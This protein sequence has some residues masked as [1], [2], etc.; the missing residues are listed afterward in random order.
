MT[1]FNVGVDIDDVL[2]P[3]FRTAHEICMAAG[4]TNGV[5]PKTY[6]PHVEYGVPRG[7]W[8]ATLDKAA[9]EGGLYDVPPIPGAVEAL[10]RIYW[11]GHRISLVTARGT[12]WP[13]SD[14]IR[15]ATEHWLEEFAVPHHDLVYTRDKDSAALELK[16]DWFIDD[17]VENYEAVAMASPMIEVYLLSAPHNLDYQTP[18]RL[19]TLDEFADLVLQ[20]A[21]R[22]AA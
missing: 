9:M 15:Q 21:E 11:A 6:A 10:R 17:S 20:A 5:E 13:S 22:K 14:L 12:D 18:F 7:D 16:L 3:W 2:H 19:E 1:I 8:L 4:M